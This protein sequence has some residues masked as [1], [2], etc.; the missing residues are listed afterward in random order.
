MSTLKPET[1]KRINKQATAYAKT[2]WPW[3]SIENMQSY[4]DYTAGAT[5][6]ALLLQQAEKYI[7]ELKEVLRFADCPELIIDNP[8]FIKGKKPT[9]QDMEW[10]RK[11]VAEYIKQEDNTWD[12]SL[13]E[14]YG[15]PAQEESLEQEN[16]RLRKIFVKILQWIDDAGLKE[17]AIDNKIQVALYHCKHLATNALNHKP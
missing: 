6:Y 8:M 14:H 7:S 1:V 10:A 11:K 5:A 3:G 12:N 13:A 17:V 2:V 15:E 9:D 16:E 4:S